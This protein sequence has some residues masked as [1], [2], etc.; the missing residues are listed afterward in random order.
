VDTVAFGF[1]AMGKPLI[2]DVVVSNATDATGRR[3]MRD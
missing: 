1:A 2:G 3:L